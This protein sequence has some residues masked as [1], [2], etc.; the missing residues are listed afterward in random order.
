MFWDNWYTN[1]QS[2]VAGSWDA[3]Q[4]SVSSLFKEPPVG[5]IAYQPDDTPVS[6]VL[7]DRK[8]NTAWDLFP[9]D[10]GPLPIATD[11]QAQ[12][13]TRPKTWDEMSFWEKAKTY[14]GVVPGAVAD[15]AGLGRQGA[16]TPADVAAAAGTA[17]TKTAETVGSAAGGLV[18]KTLGLPPGGLGGFLGSTLVKIIV[19]LVVVV[20]GLYFV[21]RITGR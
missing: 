10:P 7:R 21:A 9:V 15:T 5:S 16:T 6:D 20:V 13:A 4:A 8:S 14:V 11:I 3:A 18:N 17:V 19:G 2:A 1:A 12:I